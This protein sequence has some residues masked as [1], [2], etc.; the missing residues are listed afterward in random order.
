M[1][2]K[3]KL[4]SIALVSIAFVFMLA[5]IANAAPTPAL[6]LVKLANPLIYTDEGQTITY[7]YNVTNSGQVA[8]NAPINVTDDKFGTIIIQSTGVLSPGQSVTGPAVTYKITDKDIDRRSVTNLATATGSLGTKEI[9]SNYA[10]GVVLYEHP[11]KH[12]HD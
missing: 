8:L 10:A 1:V 7:T 6:K 11:E 4:Y 3:C 2:N 12:S 5:S 9:T